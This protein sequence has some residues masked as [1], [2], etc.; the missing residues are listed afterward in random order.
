MTEW[1]DNTPRLRKR[2]ASRRVTDVEVRNNPSAKALEVLL[3]RKVEEME[4]E[5]DFKEQEPAWL[6]FASARQ[7]MKE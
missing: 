2:T 6:A 4:Q 7:G 1:K 5:L 3:H